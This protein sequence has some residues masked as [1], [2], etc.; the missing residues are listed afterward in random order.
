MKEGEKGR[1]ETENEEG[2]WREKRGGRR[3]EGRRK[4][5]RENREEG[6]K[7]GGRRKEGEKRGGRREEGE[8]RRGRTGR[9]E[10]REEGEQG[11]RREGRR[12]CTLYPKGV[13]AWEVTAVQ[14]F[15]LIMADRQ[16]LLH[17]DT[18]K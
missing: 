14:F 15:Q 6:E 18:A 13:D 7:G 1:E 10:R 4:E 2:V 5:K 17:E 16:H 11:G 9:K 12:V 3:K 8:K